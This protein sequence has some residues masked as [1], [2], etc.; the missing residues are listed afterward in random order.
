MQTKF[1]R[2]N[3]VTDSFPWPSS[4]VILYYCYCFFKECNS[5]YIIL[6]SGSDFWH[7]IG[8]YLLNSVKC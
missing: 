8:K 4:D 5:S 3:T 7:H 2:G 1:V 6:W